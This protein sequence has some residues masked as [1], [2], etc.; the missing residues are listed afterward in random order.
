MELKDIKKVACYGSGMIGSSW[1]TLFALKGYPV[2]VFDVSEEQLVNSKKTIEGNL[3]YLAG[4][5][6]IPK[7][8]VAALL[9][10]IT[11]T[12]SVKD[13]LAGVQFIQENGPENYGIK[14]SIL[15]E[16]EKHASPDCIFA[17]STTGLLISE[18]TKDAVH[19]ERCLGAHP[20]NPPHLIPLVEMTKSAKTSEKT[21]AAAVAFYKAVGKEPVV[22]QKEKLGFISNRLSHALYREVIDLVTKGV[23][24][25]EDVDKAVCFGPGLRWA[26]F[27]PNMVYELGS[28]KGG[29]RSADK[30]K[31]TSN[32]IYNDLAD[33][34][35]MPDGWADLSQ[36]GVDVEKA[37][38]PDFM[39]HDNA[40]LIRFRDDS[41]I[42]ILKLHKKL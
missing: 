35:K 33:W 41:L 27:G 18:I 12:D 4:K 31:D 38:L 34:K 37:N 29:I 17:S 11:F 30:F 16:V 15:K 7:A 36:E 26:I 20:Y 8:K 9:G 25:I 3:N 40:D 2:N 5:G 6:V 19:P 21:I 1:A 22:L 42:E 23:C 32:M 24:T 10:K 14:Q 28:G 39:G 13:A